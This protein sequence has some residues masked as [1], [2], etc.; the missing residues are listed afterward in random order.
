M[1]PFNGCREAL[2]KQIQ[3]Q[4]I[5]QQGGDHADDHTDPGLSRVPQ[6][7]SSWPGA[8]GSMAIT[9]VATSLLAFFSIGIL[10]V[11]AFYA[12]RTRYAPA[13]RGS[14]SQPKQTQGQWRFWK[15]T[16]DSEPVHTCSAPSLLIVSWFQN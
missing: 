14:S 4:M 16:Q 8:A 15:E 9:E 13:V 1:K 5:Q 11:H 7:R 2:L 12:Y 10:A 3:N 6:E